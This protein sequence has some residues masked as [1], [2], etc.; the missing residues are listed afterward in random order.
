MSSHAQ[1]SGTLQTNNN[2]DFCNCV[3]N[4]DKNVYVHS[5]VREIRIA[6]VA[7]AYQAEE[8]EIAGKRR[9]FEILPGNDFDD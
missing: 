4:K 6:G 2:K 9:R 3:R 8:E 7:T 1:T 5:T